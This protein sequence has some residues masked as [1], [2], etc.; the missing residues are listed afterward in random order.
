MSVEPYPPTVIR[1]LIILGI[2]RVVHLMERSV[3]AQPK[4]RSHV[5]PK[6]AIEQRDFQALKLMA[7]L[8]RKPLEVFLAQLLLL[9]W[10]YKRTHYA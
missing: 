3:M 2:L 9:G 5:R 4:R 1:A 6:I 7:D 8:E 10:Q